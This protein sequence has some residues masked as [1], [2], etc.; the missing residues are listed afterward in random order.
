MP[1]ATFAWLLATKVNMDGMTAK[2]PIHDIYLSV[3]SII[4]WKACNGEDACW[5]DYLNAACS[6]VCN[7]QERIWI[8]WMMQKPYGSWNDFW[9]TSD[10]SF[11]WGDHPSLTREEALT[12]MESWDSM[13]VAAYYGDIH[14]VEMLLRNGADPNVGSPCYDP[15]LYAAAYAGHT[16]IVRLL[17]DWKADMRCRGYLG[18]PLEAAAH[19]GHA[20]IIQLLFE[21]GLTLKDGVKSL[22]YAAQMGR[23]QVIRLLLAR[24]DTDVVCSRDCSGRWLPNIAA[25]EGH[26]EATYLLLSWPDVQANNIRRL[27]SHWEWYEVLNR[28]GWE[29]D[30]WTTEIPK[31]D[32]WTIKYKDW[33]RDK[34][35]SCGQH[36]HSMLWCNC[37]YPQMMM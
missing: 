7:N 12:F 21:K 8:L 32:S 26:R 17:I 20:D 37:T 9:R 35:E 6:M 11:I 23:A 29:M 36:M 25:G 24:P 33:I 13:P 14:V 16:D 22:I 2:G 27:A 15:A 28:L 4:T 19:Q 30:D 1:R 3:A 34:C 5:Q 18:S 31:D 10:C